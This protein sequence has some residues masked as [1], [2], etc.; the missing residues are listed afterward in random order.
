MKLVIGIVHSDDADTLLKTLTEAGH[1]ATLISTTG[2]FLREGNATVFVGT[3]NDKLEEI[4]QLVRESCRK[5]TRYLSPIV[6]VTE[7]SEFYI[8]EPVELEVGGATVFVLDV[9]RYERF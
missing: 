5:R 8:P 9:E 7:P 1:K 3:E 4:L 2:G 6:P